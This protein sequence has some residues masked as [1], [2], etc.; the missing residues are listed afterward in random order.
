[1]PT[2]RTSLL[3]A[4]ALAPLLGALAACG[5]STAGHGSPAAGTPT[6]TTPASSTPGSAAPTSSAAAAA[7]GLSYVLT[8]KEL[9]SGTSWV[10]QKEGPLS[11]DTPTSGQRVWSTSDKSQAL[12]VDVV[13]LD[14]ADEASSSF[15]TWDDNSASTLTSATPQS[16]GQGAPA[17]CDLKT[18]RTSDGKSEVIVTFQQKNALVAVVL[19][20]GGGTADTDYAEQVG[21]KEVQHIN[22]VGS[23]SGSTSSSTGGAGASGAVAVPVTDAAS[24]A[25]AL[26]AQ[27]SSSPISSGRVTAWQSDGLQLN[28]SAVAATPTSISGAASF[29]TSK[30]KGVDYLAFA[31]KDSGGNCAGGVLEANSAATAVAKTTVIP[32]VSGTCTGNTVAQQAGYL[33]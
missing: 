23:G 21:G 32:V 31:V 19:V 13:A 22:G 11:S 4:L 30:S 24:A 12:E 6:P 18:G 3:S 5:G 17:N 8:T 15:K 29:V 7:S 9:P 2:S 16:C 25:R 20:N 27:A 26:V 28:G 10:Q 1:M 33:G 14:S